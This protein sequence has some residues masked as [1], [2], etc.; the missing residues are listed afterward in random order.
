M[1]VNILSEKIKP[2]SAKV[3]EELQKK[4][5]EI[6]RIAEES[7]ASEKI[8]TR[9]DELHKRVEDMR[10]L[11]DEYKFELE[12]T[13]KARPLESIVVIFIAGLIFGILLGTTSSRRR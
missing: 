3:L 6:K 5:E 11:A 13:I 1:E 2:S 12:E 10:K 7:G 4:T 9:I 8:K